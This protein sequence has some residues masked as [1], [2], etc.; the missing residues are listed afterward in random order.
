[1]RQWIA[2]IKANRV[3]GS[4][5]IEVLVALCLFS[6]MFILLNSTMLQSYRYAHKNHILLQS[7]NEY[8]TTQEQGLG[9]HLS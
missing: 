7:I 6:S 1:M 8:E 2:P 4:S 5:L 9:H 3:M